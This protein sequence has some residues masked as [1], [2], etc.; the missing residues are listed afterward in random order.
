MSKLASMVLLVF[1]LTLIV[2]P[3]L[4]TPIVF[5]S[6]TQA[7]GSTP[8]FSLDSTVLAGSQGAVYT[9]NIAGTGPVDFSYLVGGTPFSGNTS[10][11]HATLT[12][13]ASTILTGN[14]PA[15][16]EL[17]TADKAGFSYTESGYSGSFQI[18]RN[19]PVIVNGQ[20][21]SNLLSGTF[22]PP[23]A[24]QPGGADLTSVIGGTTG[25]LR[26]TTSSNPNQIVF[27]S[28]FLNFTDSVTRDATFTLSSFS[29]MFEVITGTGVTNRYPF[30]FSAV[31]SGSFAEALA[32]PA[33]EP[34]TF[35]LLASALLGLR[36]WQRKRRQLDR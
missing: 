17:C 14:C 2:T 25:T 20:S 12:L 15:G 32:V 33:P 7:L 16:G 27:T 13:S 19:S 9:V 10:P 21:F 23:F 6:Y 11:E 28:D 3:A 26:A 4:A 34:S 30:S 24:N 18:T 8:G 1:A 36:L 31:G 22:G 5:A 35:P 29:R